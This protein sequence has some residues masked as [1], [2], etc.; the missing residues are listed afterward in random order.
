MK[1]AHSPSV[2]ARVILRTAVALLVCLTGCGNAT[3]AAAPTAKSG[4]F[5][6]VTVVTGLSHPW[7]LAFLPGGDMLITERDGTLRLVRDGKLQRTPVPGVPEVRASGQ[8][9]LLDI[10][11]HPKFESNRLVYLSYSKPGPGGATTAVARGRFENDRL[12]GVEDIFVA[13]AWSDNRIHYGSRLVFD[14][15]GYL[16]LTIGDRGDSTGLGTRQRAQNLGDHAGS[17]IRLHDDGSVPKDNPFVGREG[18][19]PEIWSYG[20]RNAQGMTLH[21]TTGAIWQ[22]EHGPRGGDE[23]NIVKRGANYGWPVVTYGINYV[24]TK[25]AE[26]GDAPGMEAPILYWVPSIAPSGMAFY[27][28]DQFPEWRGNLFVGALVKQHLRRVVLEGNKVVAQEELLG[29]LGHR[30]RDVRVG[31]DGLLY[32]LVDDDDAPMLRLE[33]K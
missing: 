26:K 22:H 18:A 20:H 33:P 28:G 24:G 11:L 17:T 16:F 30:I 10:A 3:P 1:L 19:H 32:L 25:I 15:D 12:D 13:D 9:G 2:P 4:G 31:P 6:V 27:T 8:G 23:V 29:D 14:R 5:R 21:P 7:G